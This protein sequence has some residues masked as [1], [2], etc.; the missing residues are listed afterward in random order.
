MFTIAYHYLAAK[1][2]IPKLS[3]EWKNR[4]RLTIESRLATQPEL[5]GKPLSRSLKG[6]RKLRVGDYRA[7]FRIEKQIVKIFIIEHRSV[8]YKQ[9]KKRLP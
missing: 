5:Y 7:V 9:I 3:E 2:D 4:I 6:Y 8:A 1:V